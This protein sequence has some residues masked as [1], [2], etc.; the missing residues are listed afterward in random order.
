MIPHL[1]KFK[2]T[3]KGTVKAF[4]FKSVYID[5]NKGGDLPLIQV[6]TKGVITV[7]VVRTISTISLVFTKFHHTC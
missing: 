2:L 1:L 3:I 7:L 5:G 4:V 6:I